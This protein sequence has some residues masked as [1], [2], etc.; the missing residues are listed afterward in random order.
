MAGDATAGWPEL[1]GLVEVAG[2]AWTGWLPSRV[3]EIDRPEIVIAA[4]TGRFGELVMPPAGDQ[5]LVHWPADRGVGELHGKIAATT[6]G[7]LP[8]WRVRGM[9]EPVVVQ[10]RRFVRAPVTMPVTLVGDDG[11]DV[12]STIDLSEGGTALLWPAGSPPPGPDQ[13][14]T[15]VLDLEDA[16]AEVPGRVLRVAETGAG[17]HR[18]AVAFVDVAAPVADRI[19]RFVFAA[20]TRERAGAWS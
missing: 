13:D 9:G 14:L 12:L 10:R 2:P 17:A 15:L 20:L 3:D 1:N 4:P 16:T 11:V 6:R 8:S 18:V 5:V 19:R 7:R